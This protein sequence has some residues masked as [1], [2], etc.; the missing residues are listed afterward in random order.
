MKPQNMSSLSAFLIL[1][2]GCFPSYLSAE[3]KIIQEE[4]MAFDKCLN[5]ITVSETKL[6]LAPKISEQSNQRRIAVF[7]LSDGTLTITCDGKKGIVTVSTN[8]K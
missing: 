2:W 5:V 3:E 6:L 4:K 1:F 7:T 8:Q